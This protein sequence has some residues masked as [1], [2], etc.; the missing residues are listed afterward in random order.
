MLKGNCGKKNL[1][2]CDRKISSYKPALRTPFLT[3]HLWWLLLP[4][5]DL[6]QKYE[7]LHAYPGDKAIF[8]STETNIPITGLNKRQ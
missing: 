6:I 4:R 8:L 3:E 2:T 5:Y 1:T 7:F